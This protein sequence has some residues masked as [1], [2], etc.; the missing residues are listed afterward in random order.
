MTGAKYSMFM[1]PDTWREFLKE[2]Y[3]E[4]YGLMKKHNI[5][6]MHHA[7]SFCQPIAQDMVDVGID[8]WEG[9]LLKRY[10]Q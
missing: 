7:D 3:K 5:I 10:Q 6:T 8:I 9:I 1:S 2:P 4:I